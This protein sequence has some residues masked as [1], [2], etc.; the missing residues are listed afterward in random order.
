MGDLPGVSASNLTVTL[1]SDDKIHL[2]GKRSIGNKRILVQRSFEVPP[3]IDTNHARA[4][5]QDG[6]FTFLAPFHKKPGNSSV[7]MIN[8]QDGMSVEQSVAQ[9]KLDDDNDN[10][11]NQDKGDAAV[12]TVA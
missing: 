6:V 9:L 12:E 3:S 4:L 10:E 8:V 11:M 5:L 2:Q 1:S 7:Q